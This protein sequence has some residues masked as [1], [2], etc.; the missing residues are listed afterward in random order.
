MTALA[1]VAGGCLMTMGKDFDYDA[2]AWILLSLGE[3]FHISISSYSL[4]DIIKAINNKA[5]LKSNIEEKKS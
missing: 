4:V 2:L 3:I 1:A 5:V